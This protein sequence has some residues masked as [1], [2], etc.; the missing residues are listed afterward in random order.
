M[1]P[2]IPTLY[3]MIITA[4]LAMGF[5]VLFVVRG[6]EMR[7][8]KI[9]GGAM[10]I[11][12]ISHTL[13]ILRG[14]IPDLLS[15]MLGNLLLAM[16]LALIQLAIFVFQQRPL[17]Y[18]RVWFPMALIVVA[19]PFMMDNLSG[20]I[21]VSGLI[22]SLQCAL[23]L[24]T[25]WLGRQTAPGRGHYLIAIGTSTLAT[26]FLCRSIAAMLRP[27]DMSSL[28]AQNLANALPSIIGF[29]S[30]VLATMG[31]VLMNKERADE[32]NRIM[33]MQDV[34]TGIANRRA[35]L[36]ALDRHFALAQR[37]NRPLT[38]LIIDIDR[39]K[40][41]NDTFGHL[42]GDAV[43]KAVTVTMTQRLREQDLVGRYGG[44]EFLV[45]LPDTGADGGRQ[46][47]ETLRHA[48]ELTP[49]NGAD[50]PIAVTISIGIRTFDVS[51]DKT[52][53]MMIS[54]ADTALYLAKNNGRNR[55]E[56]G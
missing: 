34:L 41:I 28:F 10:L 5:A 54:H 35:I 24:H 44:E 55:V 29:I 14:Q 38:L 49:V 21:I 19:F 8:L 45:I 32:Y 47:A 7:G 20:R 16:T 13:F 18:L 15:I 17:A 3:M 52:P 25:L 53:D 36:D 48:V 33:A 39:F 31:Y 40:T 2:D 23:I 12:A 26:V 22:Y 56:V 9:W 43:I 37:S 50:G 1:H 42:A 46:L 6:T 11:N 27:A 30:I 51:S 4:S